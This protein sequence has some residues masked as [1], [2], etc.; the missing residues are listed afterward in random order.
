MK[1]LFQVQQGWRELGSAEWKR[2]FVAWL[3]FSLV[4][5]LVCS[6]FSVGYHAIDEHFQILEF[7][8][9]KLGQTPQVDLP[10]EYAAR[11]RPW[12]QPA[13]YYGIVQGL[14]TIGIQSPFTWAWVF[15]LFCSLVGWLSLVGM[16]ICSRFWF[17]D[18]RAQKFCLAAI[19][20]LWFLPPLH[21][22]PSS[23]GLGGSFFM[24]GL[25]T[26]SLMTLP[27]GLLPSGWAKVLRSR[28]TP[29]AAGLLFGLSFESRFQ[30]ALMIGGVFLWVLFFAKRPAKELLGEFT[31]CTIG[32]L[33]IFGLGRWADAWGCRLGELGGLIGWCF[34]CFVV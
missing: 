32:F 28:W 33:L 12:L 23:E 13:F 11:L 1:F 16:G 18:A 27:G 17:K 4:T 24:L 34:G 9:F 30:M 25:C 21:A 5:H 22:R 6:D 7:L 19:G 8:N 15:R 26:I 29:L 31:L 10:M 2:S 3:A 20:L 14:K